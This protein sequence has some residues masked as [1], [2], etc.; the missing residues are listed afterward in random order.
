MRSGAR[1]QRD[2]GPEADWRG[3]WSLELSSAKFA[4]TLVAFNLMYI[5]RLQALCPYR[6]VET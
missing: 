3:L 4:G 6:S 5:A 1:L 2:A